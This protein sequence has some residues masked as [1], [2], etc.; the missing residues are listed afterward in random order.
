M[1]TV[2]TANS[3][4]AGGHNDTAE[5]LA[6]TGVFDEADQFF[7]ALEAG[8]NVLNDHVD[9]HELAERLKLRRPH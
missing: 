2:W 3:R 5:Q 1:K 9:P 8:E 6:A 7:D 4:S